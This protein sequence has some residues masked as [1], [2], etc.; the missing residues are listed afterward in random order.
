VQNF[1]IPIYPWAGDYRTVNLGKGG[2]QFA[3]APRIAGLMVE[4]ERDA[5][6]R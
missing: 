1:R 2:F 4:F 6:R 5:L 3:H